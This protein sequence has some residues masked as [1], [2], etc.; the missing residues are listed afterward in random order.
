MF[1]F[2]MIKLVRR[3]G[4]KMDQP[5]RDRLVNLYRPLHWVPCFLHSSFEKWIKRRH[6]IPVIIEFYQSKNACS[7]GLKE[8]QQVA[9]EHRRCKINHEFNSISCCSATLTANA[10]EHL[11]VNGSQIKKIHYDR[12]VN[13]LLD[14]ASPSIHANHVNDSGLTGKDVTI[15]IIDTGIYPHPDLD[16]RILAFKDLVNNRDTAYDDNGHGTHCA[17][18]AA[19]NGLSS[20]GKYKGPAS[21]ANVVGVKVLNRTGSGSLST[22][23]AG[24]QWCIDHKETYKINILSMSLGSR[25]TQSA[26]DDPVVRIVEQAWERGMVVCVAAGNDGPDENTIASPGISPTVITVG[27]MEDHNTVNRSDDTIASFSSRGPTIDG[28]TKPD[29]LTP[30]VDIVSLRSPNSFLDKVSKSS[31]VGQHYFSLSGT[32]MA[33]PICAG[34]AALVLQQNTNLTPDQVKEKLLNSAE[35]WGLP[36]NTQGKGYLDAE[37]GV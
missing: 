28:F 11:I 36:P 26:S 21:E 1:G 23:I 24:V 27:A 3:F 14:V 20:D 29:L 12:E 33:T 35:D 17:G 32:S 25:A 6:R 34:V 8:V 13:A 5:L 19:G 30:G 2:S 10:V 22:V 9:S 15:A 4:D 37:K 16:S 18:D 31:R 7:L